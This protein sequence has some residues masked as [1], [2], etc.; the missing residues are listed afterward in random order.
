MF[1]RILRSVMVLGVLVAVYQAYAAFIVPRME[2]PLAL[3]EQ[4]ALTESDREGAAWSVTKYQLLLRNYFP[5][6]HWSQSRQ[7]KVIANGTEQVMLVFD[8][9]R[10]RPGATQNVDGNPTALVDIDR[11]AFLM[12]PTPP[13]EGVTPPRDA[14]V[15]EAQRG[16]QLEFDEFRPEVGKIGQI[17]RGE[18]PGL[19]RIRSDMREEGPDD[20]LLIETADLRM[21]TKLMYSEAPVRFRMGENYGGGTELEIRFIADEHKKPDSRGLKIAGID[22]LE[23]RRDVKLRL[24]MA[25]GDML[26]KGNRSRDVAKAP[27]SPRRVQSDLTP[28]Y[29][30]GENGGPAVQV[31]DARAVAH[32]NTV[33]PA[34]PKPPLEVSCTGPFTFDCVRYVASLDHDVELRQIVP[35]GPSDQL[36]CAR[37]D[38]HFAPKQAGTHA[39]TTKL[40]EGG[41]RQ[42]R[43]LGQLEP[44]AIVAEGH[45]VVMTS[46]ARN[47]QARG[48]RIQIALR[49]QR[50]RISGADARLVYGANVLQAPMI[51]YEHPAPNE[52]SAVGSFRAAGPG[53]LHFVTDPKKPHEALQAEWQTAVQLGRD[54][55][56]PVLVLEGRP[57]IAFGETGAMMAD[58][59]RLYLREL[60][61]N[62]EE[63]LAIG[64]KKG[65]GQQ[66]IRLAPDRVLAV[67]NVEIA[68]PQF[69]SRANSLTATFQLRPQRNG[70]TTNPASPTNA[71]GDE[72]GGNQAAAS[73][74]GGSSSSPTGVPGTPQQRYYIETKEMRLELFLTGQALAPSTLVCDGGVLLREV[75]LV[76]THE[77]PLEIRGGQL[78]VD[79]LDTPAA[80]ITLHGAAA[81]Q[82]AGSALA[83]LSGRGITMLVGSVEAVANE[84]RVFSTGPGK[85]TILVSNT[86]PTPAAGQPTE[87][88]FPIEIG[89]Q[90]GFQFNGEAIVFRR[91]VVATGASNTGMNGNLHCDQLAARLASKV[92]LGEP[93]NQGNFNLNEIEC[94]GNVML[95]NV[96]RDE[97]GITSHSF[98]QLEQ[99]AL[100]QQTGQ[101]AGKGPGIVRATRFGKTMVPEAAQPNMPQA[102]ATSA[103]AAGNKL[104]FLRVD[105]HQGLNGNIYLRDL[106]FHQRVRTT[107]GPVDSW[108]QELD[109]TRPETLPPDALTLACDALR[110]NEDPLATR[111][112]ANSPTG[113]AANPAGL[114]GGRPLGPMQLQA[115]GDVRIAGQVPNQ[116]EFTVQALRASYDQAKDAFV[117]EGDSRSPAKLW[118][119]NQVGVD[120]PP[121][122]ARKIRYVRSLNEVKVEGIQYFEIT[123]NDIQN[124]Q[125]PTRPTK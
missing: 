112:L 18:F 85:A 78:L 33:P 25:V 60:E 81:G 36:T 88:P 94:S 108:D 37:L 4:R 69:T 105:F 98:M 27:P 90:D 50:L 48:D 119:R 28:P 75:P 13:R 44:V 122:E 31:T 40:L 121:T 45:P 64:G 77:Q 83:Q 59:I 100:N 79:S 115:L 91:D 104:H 73:V 14:I 23:I 86:T 97:G 30:G 26:P 56:Q 8:E 82:P 63:G 29:Q 12:F 68:S 51:D 92:R 38:I 74:P 7:P 80:H 49:D 107:Y 24:Q 84:N 9:F 16:A 116:G 52:G 54:Q 106:T 66:M 99:L 22:S 15:L 109:P 17:I 123:P 87:A 57:K 89:W 11:I 1:R 21:N 42:H 76:P 117:L 72:L 118:R 53:S 71:A 61:G 103:N 114:L 10:R 6:D 70:T 2:P 113:P 93:M 32:A 58:Q 19:I 20:D 102:A 65:D 34:T 95:E 120:S 39:S 3:R 41:N 5:N 125:R 47:A 67:G 101:I 62:G 111:G 43:D 110:L 55:G 96:S 124:A 46:P 35:E